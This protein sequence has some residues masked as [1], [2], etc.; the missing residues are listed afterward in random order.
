MQFEIK[1]NALIA[2]KGGETLIIE[3][4]GKDSLRVR[5][6]MFN[7]VTR[8]NWALTESPKCDVKPEIKTFLIV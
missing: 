1:E 5:S 3:P 7:D 2:K 8:N 4:W 6:T